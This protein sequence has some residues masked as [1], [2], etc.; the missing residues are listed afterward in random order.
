M[1]IAGSLVNHD[2]FERYLGMRVET[3]DMVEFVRR[4]ERKI[5]DDAEY[6]RAIAWTKVH[7][8]EGKD[9]NSPAGQFSAAEKERVWEW[10]VKM[11]MIARDLMVGNPR[12]A[13]VGLRRR[14]PGPQRHRRRLS[15]PAPV[16]RP[17]A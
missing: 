6:Q 12:L 11:T 8:K 13:R 17:P 16:D 5:F 7:C 3:V 15:R 10:S 4:V 2:F 14:G 9:Y 1:G